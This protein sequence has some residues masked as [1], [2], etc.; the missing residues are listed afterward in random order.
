MT[1]SDQAGM[2]APADTPYLRRLAGMRVTYDP[3]LQALLR[4]IETNG[5][6]RK[7]ARRFVDRFMPAITA[8][9]P[10][11]ASGFDQAK[12]AWFT[13]P[14][15]GNYNLARRKLTERVHALVLSRR[16]AR[17]TY[18]TLSGLQR[19]PESQSAWQMTRNRA[20]AA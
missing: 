1:R 19:E 5:H 2:L 11:I 13:S 6:A 17:T 16:E 18:E 8:P 15:R 10:F 20:E 7:V 12:A 14:E 3:K 4:N 9:N